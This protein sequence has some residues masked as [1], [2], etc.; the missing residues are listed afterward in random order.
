MFKPLTLRELETVSTLFVM[1]AFNV[2]GFS[3]PGEE[4]SSL[5]WNFIRVIYRHKYGGELISY[6]KNSVHKAWYMCTTIIINKKIANRD[7]TW[8]DETEV[9]SSLQILGINV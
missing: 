9:Q 6:D 2:K 1:V 5:V 3:V 8:F 4:H 7:S